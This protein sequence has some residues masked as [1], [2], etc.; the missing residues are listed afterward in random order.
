VTGTASG[1]RLFVAA[2]LILTAGLVI[3]RSSHAERVP[4]RQP[5]SAFPYEF[6]EWRGERGAELDPR[7]LA[8]L[9]ADDYLT[10]VYAGPDRG[11]VDF[12][13]G[14]YESQRQGDLIHSPMNCLPGSGWEPVQRDRLSVQVPGLSAPLQIN[15]FVI[16]KGE[17]RQVVLYWYQ[18]HGRAMA[19]EY[20]SRMRMVVD[21]VRIN[22]T[23]AAL[24]RV[25]TPIDPRLGGE[26][27]AERRA[28]A[29]VRDM[30]PRL[31]AH[32]PV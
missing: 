2:A 17:Y 14:Y 5:L 31:A 32:L 24:V 8:V 15:R 25:V 7:L 6:N 3:A 20:V 29:F 12:Y 4:P 9:G 23:D 11:P 1:I 26:A 16:Q 18:S 10:R 30:Y 13:V 22:R 27:A 21:A 28:V 19:S